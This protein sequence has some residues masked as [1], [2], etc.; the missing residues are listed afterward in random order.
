MAASGVPEIFAES[1]ECV[2]LIHSVSPEH[3]HSIFVPSMAVIVAVI[4]W[5]LRAMICDSL[6]WSEGFMF[7]TFTVS[8]DFAVAVIPFDEAL[9][10]MGK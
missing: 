10:M 5:P 7:F 6:A 1:P 3:D 4:W 9:T 8:E 2:K